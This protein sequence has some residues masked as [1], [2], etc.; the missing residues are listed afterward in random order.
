MDTTVVTEPY[1][2]DCLSGYYGSNCSNSCRYPSYGVDCQEEC[3]C[4][5]KVCDHVFGCSN[6]EL[7]GHH[8]DNGLQLIIGLSVGIGAVLIIAAFLVIN[9]ANRRFY[10]RHIRANAHYI[11]SV[12][13][14]HSITTDIIATQCRYDKYYNTKIH[15]CT[16]CLPGYYGLNCRESCRYPN[17]E[18]DNNNG[19]LLIIGLSKK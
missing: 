8:N 2:I 9:I 6:Y 3:H 12:V 10:T 1:E 7:N 18:H 11:G 4:P 13:T 14:E 16:D 19:H 15:N 5:K 17:Y